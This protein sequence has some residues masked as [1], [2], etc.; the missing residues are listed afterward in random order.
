[1]FQSAYK[2]AKIDN[3]AYL[4]HIS[5]YIHLN[6]QDIGQDPLKYPYSSL[7]NYLGG[8]STKWLRYKRIMRLH[9]NDKGSYSDFVFDYADYRK[10]LSE[11][12]KDLAA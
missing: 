12:K 11:V 4:Y 10:T 6:P 9:L 3:E 8:K 2:A 5:R 7:T 1:M